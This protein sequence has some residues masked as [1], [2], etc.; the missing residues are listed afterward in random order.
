M[1]DQSLLKDKMGRYRTM[2]LFLEYNQDSSTALF[3]IKPYDH[4]LHGVSYL[5]LKKIYLTFEDPTEYEFAIAVFG[6]WKHWQKI[7]NNSV[8][9]P[10]IMEWRDELEIK[11]RS[12]AIRAIIGAAVGEGSKGT[13]AAKWIAEGQWKGK[14]SNRG[15]PSKEEV[16]RIKKIHAGI[17]EDIDEDAKRI[18][19]H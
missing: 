11:L 4:E 19:V 8:L 10:F 7:C 16:E 15:R 2:S 18:G 3:T 5:S 6:D 13:A 12:R 17:S 9:L 1:I 14:G